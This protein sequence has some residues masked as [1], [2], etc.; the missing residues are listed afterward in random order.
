MRKDKDKRS[1][2]D[3]YINVKTWNEFRDTGLLW[4]INTILNVFGWGIYIGLDDE[5]NIID[6]FPTRCRFRGFETEI[7]DEGYFLV[8]KYLKDNAKEIYDEFKPVEEEDE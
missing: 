2:D 1:M 5:G 8:S 4:F 3:D 7:N 6:A